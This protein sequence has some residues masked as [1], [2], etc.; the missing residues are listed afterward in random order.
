MYR[1]TLVALSN[2]AHPALTSDNERRELF[3]IN[4]PTSLLLRDAAVDS[5]S[6]EYVDLV[7]CLE[8]QEVGDYDPVD[9]EAEPVV[10]SCTRDGEEVGIVMLEHIQ[11]Y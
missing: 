1:A 10:L 5:L 6:V 11:A 7:D 9:T 2:K 4:W 8:V 3:F